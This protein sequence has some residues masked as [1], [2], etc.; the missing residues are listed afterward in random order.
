MTVAPQPSWPPTVGRYLLYAEIASGGMATVHFGRLQGAAGFARSVAI[1]RL[2]PQYARD[3][4]FV[5]MFLDEARLAA[6]I[7]HPNVVPT[8]DVVAQGDEL[9]LVMDYVR[10]SALSRLLRTL[11]QLGERMPARI[12]AA[13]AAGVL[14]G[15]HAAHE[16]TNELGEPLEIVHR[17]V[18]PQNVLV[19]T[20]GIPRVLDFGVAKAAGRVQTTREGQLKGKLAYMAPEQITTGSVTRKTDIY[21]AAVVLWEMLTG[22]RLFRAD[23]EGKLLALV[24]DGDVHPP[25]AL[26]EGLNEGF[27]RVVL[28]GMDRDPAKRYSTAR[29]MAID[30]ESVVGIAPSAEVG[31][32]VEALA[33]DELRERTA[34]IEEIERSVRG[35][36]PPSGGWSDSLTSSGVSRRT[37]EAPTVNHGGRA[38]SRAPIPPPKP[39]EPSQP[40]MRHGVGRLSS[41]VPVAPVS[42]GDVLKPPPQQVVSQ[43]SQVSHFSVSHTD[44][45]RA[46]KRRSGGLV[47]VA[48]VALCATG[49]AIF[50]LRPSHSRAA[51]S[52]AATNVPSA[53]AGAAGQSAKV[54]QAPGPAASSTSSASAA[55]AP[56]A[57]SAPKTAVFEDLP[58]PGA[59]IPKMTNAQ[60]PRPQLSSQPPQ[61]VPVQ[62]QGVAAQPRPP[63]PASPAPQVPGQGQVTQTPAPAKRPAASDC[64]PPYTTDEKGHIHFKPACL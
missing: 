57:S 54:V 45:P 36:S 47:V 40:T 58:A 55:S 4:D 32:W 52:L 29:E 28:R 53:T 26:V 10:G 30:V 35:S 42:S 61:P 43:V 63:P 8:L 3:P 46:A 48:A 50:A 44:P 15:L 31:E 21:A 62:G 6:R 16:A 17:D 11:T 18:S 39:P 25:S 59:S 37:D 20:D 19:G 7:A 5:E 38:S 13:I 12:A 1:K 60:H 51:A 2:H 49:A 33:A 24:L 22:R 27:D 41:R 64:N 14:R 23:N 56:A 34:R 9:L